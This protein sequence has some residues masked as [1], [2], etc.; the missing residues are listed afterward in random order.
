MWLA[1]LGRK[2]TWGTFSGRRKES[3]SFMVRREVEVG[4]WKIHSGAILPGSIPSGELL[5]HVKLLVL[6]L[7]LHSYV[8]LTFWLPTG[9]P[10]LC[11]S[12]PPLSGHPSNSRIVPG[13]HHWPIAPGCLAL[14]QARSARPAAGRGLR[15]CCSTPQ[16]VLVASAARKPSSFFLPAARSQKKFTDRAA[17]A[18]T[19]TLCH[20]SPNHLQPNRANNS[21]SSGRRHPRNVC[22]QPPWPCADCGC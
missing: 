5:K 18:K 14:R 11:P 15:R 6:V 10:Y 7:E 9:V 16:P 4:C 17:A 13:T 12:P 3:T 1:V 2:R 20:T 19:Q 22:W 21:N 8:R